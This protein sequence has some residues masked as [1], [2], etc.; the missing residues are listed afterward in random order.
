ML[1]GGQQSVFMTSRSPGIRTIH[2]WRPFRPLSG[3]R[4]LSMKMH[5]VGWAD[6]GPQ[7]NSLSPECTEGGLWR[8]HRSFQRL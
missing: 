7:I 3:V 2:T 4:Y 6:K 5:R 1:Q 8:L